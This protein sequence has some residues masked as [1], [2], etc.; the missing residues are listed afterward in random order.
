MASTAGVEAPA[1]RRRS[2]GAGRRPRQLMVRLSEEEFAVLA[3]AAADA[4]LTPTGFAA[5]AAVD[6]AR[7]HVA[8][9]PTLPREVLQKLVDCQRQLQR[10]GVL[11]NQAVAKLHSTGTE[12]TALVPAIERYLDSLTLLD[13][14]ALRL[15][16]AL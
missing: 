11:V 6:F 10:F 12:P 14:T 16:R 15:Q 2:R 3:S 1:V 9:L 7:S 5:Q 8:P 4:G 13:E